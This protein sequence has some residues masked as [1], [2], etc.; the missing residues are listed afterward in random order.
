M[1]AG[2]GGLSVF[3]K[4]NKYSAKVLVKVNPSWE[5][6]TWLLRLATKTGQETL[7]TVT[8]DAYA[9]FQSVEVGRIYEFKIPGKCVRSN[10]SGQKN[11]IVSLREVTLKYGCQFLL[12][13][14]GW[15]TQL[16]F[17]IVH[18]KDLTQIVPDSWVDVY[19]TVVEILE[20]NERKNYMEMIGLKETGLDRL[21]QKGYKILELETFFT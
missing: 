4:I 8:G 19:A 12:A 17:N 3:S 2:E 18:F 1:E 5:K 7:M 15:T 10:V 9:T 14:E 16:P 11:G 21:I 20:S 13:T 6:P